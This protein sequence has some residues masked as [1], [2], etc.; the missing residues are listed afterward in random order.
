MSDPQ[1]VSAI[2]AGLERGLRERGAELT[3]CSPAALARH[4]VAELGE[5]GLAMSA[6]QL[7]AVTRLGEI[8]SVLEAADDPSGSAGSD[9]ETTVLARIRAIAARAPLPGAKV[10]TAWGVRITT[11]GV[12][13]VC[14]ALDPNSAQ[15]EAGAFDE[16]LRPAVMSRVVVTGPWTPAPTAELEAAPTTVDRHVHV[17]REEMP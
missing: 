6:P 5:R 1:I 2:A 7:D 3:G 15:E 9:A 11:G 13:S 12:T 14:N 4:A 10:R 16:R 8:A 17:A